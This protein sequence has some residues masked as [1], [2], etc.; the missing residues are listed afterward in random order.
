MTEFGAGV[1]FLCRKAT[2]QQ[3]G[4]PPKFRSTIWGSFAFIGLALGAQTT[5]AVTAGLAASIL[6]AALAV[7]AGGAVDVGEVWLRC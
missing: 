3:R 7:S 2:S 6:S 1:D 4:R 5:C